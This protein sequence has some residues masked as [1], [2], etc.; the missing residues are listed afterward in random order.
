MVMKKKAPATRIRRK[1]LT[2]E[3][4]LDIVKMDE[5]G[6][7]V[8]EIG[9]R[10]GRC[11]SIVSRLL[12]SLPYS[13]ANAKLNRY[14]KARALTER[15]QANRT[16]PRRKQRLKC[17]ELRCYV[18]EK[19]M[20]GWTP[21]LIA[22]RVALELPGMSTNHES[23]YQWIAYDRQDLAKYLPCNG[24][25][26]RKKRVKKK[27][28]KAALPKRSIEQRPS[29][30]DERSRVGDFE[31]DTIVSRQS[32]AAIL[33]ITERSCR[34]LILE[35]LKDCTATSGAAA[36]KKVFDTLPQSMKHTLTLDNGSENAAHQLIDKQNGITTFYCHPYTASE[37]G[38]VENRNKFLR[39]FWGKKTDFA[40]LSYEEIKRVQDI[41]N[42][43]PMKCLGFRTPHE[44]FYEAHSQLSQAQT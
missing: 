3:E 1:P 24:K 13:P 12:R 31:G 35:P 25:K 28:P 36:M 10:V 20:L 41:H 27:R 23:I 17:H 8:R 18:E 30:V 32:K 7:G 42:H 40:T 43:R 21:E 5:L 44:V 9:R 22:G 19:I 33:N 15:A 29:V 26:K 2:P 34:F 6:L 14:E 4:R 37:R 39:Q 16:K 11:H 38:T